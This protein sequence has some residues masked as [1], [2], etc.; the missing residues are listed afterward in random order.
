ML[1]PCI[2]RIP[3]PQKTRR[4]KE[5][6]MLKPKKRKKM[7]YFKPEISLK[8]CRSFQKIKEKKILKET[9]FRLL[10]VIITYN[11]TYFV[12]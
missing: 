6:K 10:Y 3:S 8:L 5:K 11:N 2:T 9:T 1:Q 4:F 12:V 7:Y